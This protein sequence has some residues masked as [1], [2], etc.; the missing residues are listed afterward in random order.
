MVMTDD[1]NNT[2]GGEQGK[3]RWRRKAKE[4]RSNSLERG[5]V[6]ISIKVSQSYLKR[7]SK[8][9]RIQCKQKLLFN[10]ISF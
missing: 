4:N 1:S 5:G 3:R 6:A 8:I 7:K 2:D 9:D 10:S